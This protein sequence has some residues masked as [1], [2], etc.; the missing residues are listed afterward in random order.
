MRRVALAIVGRSVV[1]FSVLAQWII[2]LRNVHW[3]GPTFLMPEIYAAGAWIGVV[4]LRNLVTYHA[5][6]R[7]DEWDSLLFI[8]A[9]HRVHFDIIARIEEIAHNPI[10]GGVYFGRDYPFEI[11]AFDEADE[12]GVRHIDPQRLVPLLSTGTSALIEVGG[13]GTGC[14]LIR[15]DILQRMAEHVGSTGEVWH[16]DRLPWATQLRLIESG[17]SVSGVFTE[18]ILFCLDVKRVLGERTLLDIDSRMETGHVG[19]E[20]RDR[21]HYLA[22]HTVPQGVQVDEAALARQGYRVAPLNR[23]ERRAAMGKGRR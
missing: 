16:A 3:P 8:D 19:E 23:R 21:R 5:L 14:M 15:K 11:Q 22:A 12:D 18:D 7:A 20:T 2:T 4:P 9:D 6:Q 17:E 13:V 1:S 10:V